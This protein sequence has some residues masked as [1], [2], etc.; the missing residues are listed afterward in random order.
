MKILVTGG[1]GFLGVRLIKAFLARADGGRADVRVVAADTLPCPIH[2]SRVE[3]R[4]GTVTD[5]AFITHIVDHD[6]DVVCHLAAVL[7]GQS[8]SEFDTGM[9]VNVEGTRNL[10]EACRALRTAPRFV[11][12]STIAVFGGGLPDVI[13]GDLAVT[14][15]SSYGTAKA[16]GELLVSDYSRRGF[17]DGVA[18]RVPTVAIRPGAPNS[19]LS[20]FAS[21]IIRE[22]LNGLVSICP[23]PLDTRIWISSPDTATANLL[24]AA[25]FPTAGLEG[26]RMLN[27]PGLS[28]TPAAM[29]DSLERLAGATARSLV[30]CE[31]DPATMRIVCGWPGAFEVSR[32]LRLGFLGD[33]SIDAVVRQ[34]MAERALDPH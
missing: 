3:S 27:L 4:I 25:T 9:R 20:S 21:G 29:L 15:Q 18:C 16:I 23:V 30:G 11:F 1:A 32:P 31:P 33:E 6:V 24:H 22:P 10:L 12:T 14:P 7:S 5:Q 2:D 28:V 8:E 34:F 13:P 17:I 19:A 26:R